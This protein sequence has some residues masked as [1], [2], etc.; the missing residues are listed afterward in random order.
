M[1]P[2]ATSG[3]KPDGE[4]GPVQRPDSIA[5][6]AEGL[7]IEAPNHLLMDHNALEEIRRFQKPGQPDLVAKIVV[8]YI[9]T[10]RQL[11]ENLRV[12]LYTH[13]E[14]GVREAAHALKSSSAN[15]GALAVFESAKQIEA[16]ARTSQL[17]AV[18]PLAPRLFMDY[19]RTIAA[20]AALG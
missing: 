14:R 9:E 19:E 2:S 8:L 5:A 15:I 1:S 4:R 18:A 11:I 16:L 6:L 17:T 3:D 10:S 13:D 20:L 12:A 7:P